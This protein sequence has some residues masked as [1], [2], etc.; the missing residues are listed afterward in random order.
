MRIRDADRHLLAKVIRSPNRLYVLN[1]ELVAPVCLA[2][3]GAE[4]AWLWHARYGHLNFPALR[5]LAWKSMVCGLPEVEQAGQVC[6][7]CLAG[8]HHRAMFSRQAKYRTGESLVLVH[9]DLCRL[10]AP[11]RHLVAASTSFSLLT[12]IAAPCGYALCAPR[13]KPRTPSSSFSS[14][15]RLKMGAS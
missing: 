4:S 14:W 9:G 2:S 11:V 3:R 12:T 5:R 1:V 7:E 8:K 13:I 10:I 6:R 15:Q